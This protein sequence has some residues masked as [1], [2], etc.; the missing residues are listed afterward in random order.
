MKN[1]YTIGETAKIMGISVQVLRKYS[2]MGL[3]TPEYVDENTGYR[4][5]SFNQ[6]HFIDKIIYFRKLGIPL[7]EIKKAISL[8]NSDNLVHIL[9]E[10]KKYLQA[11]IRQTQAS[12]DNLDWYINYFEYPNKYKHLRAPYIVHLPHRYALGMNYLNGESVAQI[13]TRLAELRHSR[14]GRKFHYMRQYGYIIDF[15]ELIQGSFQ[16]LNHF[17]FVRDIP[18]NINEEIKKYI[19]HFPEGEYL[20][21][22]DTKRLTSQFLSSLSGLSGQKEPLAIASE[23]ENNLSEYSIGLFEIEI[24]INKSEKA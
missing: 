17:M 7:S 6:F 24:L 21:F 22:F 15:S 9:K 23:Y 14:E 20:C 13:E 19:H 5:F 8:K 16:A 1:L 12:A 10:Q 11:V 2:N 18:P 3:I 4:Y